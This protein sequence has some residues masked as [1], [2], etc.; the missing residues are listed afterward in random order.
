M[1]RRGV[2]SD[3]EKRLAALRARGLT[4]QG[5]SPALIETEPRQKTTAVTLYQALVGGRRQADPGR[6]SAGAESG[7]QA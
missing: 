7:E 4:A 5:G 1:D 3:L 2:L 6:R